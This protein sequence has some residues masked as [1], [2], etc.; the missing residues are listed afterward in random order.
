MR[1]I[2]RESL[3]P[4]TSVTPTR[5]MWTTLPL[6]DNYER[7]MLSIRLPAV[8]LTKRQRDLPPSP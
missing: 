2:N 3:L 8:T 5:S 7:V 1:T 6:E 4:K